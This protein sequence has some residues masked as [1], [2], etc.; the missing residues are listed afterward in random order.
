MRIV[1]DGNIGTGKTT[2]LGL[3][4]K[5][6]WQVRREPIDKWPLEE[7]YKDPS[8]WAFLLHM[9]ILQTLRP[10]KT[11]TSVLYERS[12][13]SSRWVFW[14]VLQKHGNVTQAEHETYDAFYDQY[15]WFPD[16]YIFLAKDVEK[17]YEH[18]TKRS[19]AGDS[20]VTLE[21]MKELDAEYQKLIR[22]VPCKVHV[23]NANRSVS[24]IHEEI[25]RILAENEL[26]FSDSH[27]V[28]MQK[29]GGRGRKM[30]CTSFEHMCSVS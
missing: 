26:L 24:E 5:K 22:Q 17:A 27:G 4:E 30:S 6:G 29:E 19:Q 15:S 13:M 8:R 7:F 21:Y 20:G 11:E 1:I 23:V 18:V 9:K 12:I 2:Q 28:Q 25:C 16:L 3:L 10:V 14:P